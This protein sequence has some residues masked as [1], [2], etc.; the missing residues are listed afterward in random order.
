MALMAL[1]KVKVTNK[2]SNKI[3]QVSRHVERTKTIRVVIINYPGAMQ[4][5]V[6]GLLELLNL[7][8]KIIA[9]EQLAMTFSAQITT[10]EKLSADEEGAFDLTPEVIILPPNLDGEYYLNAGQPLLNF[11]K[12]SHQAG[13]TLCSACAGAFILAQTSLLTNR[14]ATTH[15]GL[16]DQLQREYPQIRLKSESILINDGDIVSAGGLMSWLDLGLELV[17]QYAKP[18]VMRKLGKYLIVD[19]GKREQRYYQSFTPIFDHGNQ[20]MLAVQHYIQ[21]NYD[22]KLNNKVLAGVAHTS[23]RTL[24]R[25]FTQATGLKPVQYIQ[26]LRVQKACDMLESSA[27]SFEQIALSLGYEDA[28]SLRKVFVKIVGLAPSEFRARFI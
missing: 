20:A 8:N 13:S 26:R 17:G 16:A 9:D 6:Y 24:I 19:T 28:S 21:A 27:L 1:I 11:L 22:T 4:S 18:H 10:P 14:T 23:E 5:A 7:A 15:W 12:Q 25:Q 2:G 3:K